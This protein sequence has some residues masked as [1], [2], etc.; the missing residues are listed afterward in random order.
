MIFHLFCDN[1]KNKIFYFHFW[2]KLVHVHHWILRR[3]FYKAAYL[4]I[5]NAKLLSQFEAE[6]FQLV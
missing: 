4:I 2:P 1:S 6:Q 3:Y 5:I